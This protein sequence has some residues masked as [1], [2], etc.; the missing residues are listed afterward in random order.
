MLIAFRMTP[1]YIL[2]Q[3][4]QRLNERNGSESSPRLL[5]SDFFL[6][7]SQGRVIQEVQ[8]FK[9]F[10]TQSLQVELNINLR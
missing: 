3:S 9:K 5:S 1:V 6:E 8:E 2:K 4:V 7:S 10:K